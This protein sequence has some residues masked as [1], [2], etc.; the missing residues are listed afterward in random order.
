MSRHILSALCA[1]AISTVGAGTLQGAEEAVLAAKVPATAGVLVNQ[2]LDAEIAGDAELRA[3]KLRQAQE[4]DPTFAP[5][6]WHAGMV[7]IGNTWSTWKEAQDANPVNEKLA[8]YRE[9]RAESKL[10]PASH[11]K[12]AK[13]CAR[14][15]L[16][17]QSRAHWVQVLLAQ[18][19]HHSA[20]T[21]L[22][23]KWYGGAL[24]SRDEKRQ[25]DVQAEEMQKARKAWESKATRWRRAIV[26]G[27]DEVR[28][29]ALDELRSLDDPDAIAVIAQEF[30]QADSHDERGA[31]L[32][33]AM[34]EVLGRI[35]TELSTRLLISY[36]VVASSEAIRD[37]AIYILKNRPVHTYVPH[38]LAGMAMPLE[39]GATVSERGGR[40]LNSYS[41]S[42]EGPSGEDY[43]TSYST[44]RDVGQRY[45]PMYRPVTI[46]GYDKIIPAKTG[47]NRYIAEQVIRIPDKVVA[48]RDGYSSIESPFYRARK[49]YQYRQAQVD[50]A[51][52]RRTVEELNRKTQQQNE[53]I[54]KVLTATT[55]VEM[56]PVARWWWDWWRKHLDENPSVRR[57]T[58]GNGNPFATFQWDHHP[59]SFPEGTLVW[60]RGGPA[61]I[62]DV[63]VG[64]EVLSQDPDTGE[65]AYKVVADA[66]PSGKI[67]MHL[68]QIGEKTSLVSAPGNLLWTTGQGWRMTQD[69][70]AG[71]LLHGI[72][73]SQSIDDNQIAKAEK[74]YRLLVLDFHTL[75]IGEEG[76]LARD[77]TMPAPTGRLLPGLAQK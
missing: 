54:A 11:V 46:P 32:H 35:E 75:L 10:D 50:A 65:V 19:K 22:G 18:P 67:T 30:Y 37:S 58:L 9:L 43:E 31:Q 24:L 27:N 26:S 8:R 17:E 63:K 25:L 64:D 77:A 59:G 41:I 20:L 16:P 12:L 73:G 70:K 13:W 29:A 76:I 47:C 5:A 71:A 4:Q 1:V 3:A 60:T 56:E 28:Q 61:P 52:V 51:G 44:S 74:A 6:R 39:V 21:A 40:I 36:A 66:V 2:A 69:L 55:S 34:V 57:A 15:D 53:R 45:G 48:V 68:L 23:L 38:L 14:N 72:E 62:Q 42:R 49:Q 33:A 7:R